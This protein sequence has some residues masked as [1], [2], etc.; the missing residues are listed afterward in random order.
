MSFLLH[1]LATAI[2]KL[3]KNQ[4]AVMVALASRLDLILTLAIA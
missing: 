2:K 4:D 3:D 1:G